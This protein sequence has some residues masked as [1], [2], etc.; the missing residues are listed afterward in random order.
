MKI[1][2]IAILIL[3]SALMLSA[4]TKKF[5]WTTDLCEFEG[6]YDAKKYTEAQLRNTQELLASVG[7]I[8]LSTEITAWNYDDIKKFSV[9]ELDREYK[10]KSE[11]LKNLD[12]VK[13]EY[14]ETMRQNKLKETEQSYK[15]SRLTIQAYT[16]PAIL[17]QNNS[18]PACVKK[19]A[20]PLINGGNDLLKVWR[21]VNEESRKRNGDPERVRKI[22]D[23]E[24]DSPDKLKYALVEVMSFGWWNCAN[25]TIE[26]VVSDGE[27]HEKF[28][29]LFKNVKTI[30]CDEP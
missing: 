6:T 11:K 17:K 26:Y 8:P 3:C 18:A 15:L 2:S 30:Y 25:E 27:Q 20:G 13:S 4:Q 16:N 14:W 1:F 28:N 29:Q 12:I 21:Q 9:E 24:Y 23:Q 19:Y 7:S 5:R 10:Q 22:F